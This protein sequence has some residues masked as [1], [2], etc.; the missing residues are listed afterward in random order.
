MGNLT[1]H[2]TAAT[3]DMEQAATASGDRDLIWK[4]MLKKVI[5]LFSAQQMKTSEIDGN[6]EIL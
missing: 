4:K 5:E 3:K 1:E 6:K 2:E